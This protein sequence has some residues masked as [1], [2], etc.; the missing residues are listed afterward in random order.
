M[1][2]TGMNRRMDITEMSNINGKNVCQFHATLDSENL[3]SLD[4]I[5]T[6]MLPEDYRA[7]QTEV[8]RDQA[9][10]EQKIFAIQ[11]ELLNQEEN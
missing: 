3:E 6:M 1:S 7:N 5:R 10:F 11:D 4:L 9:A 8:L 2:L